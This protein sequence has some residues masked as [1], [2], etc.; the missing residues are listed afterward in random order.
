MAA[1]IFVGPILHEIVFIIESLTHI[2]TLCLKDLPLLLFGICANGENSLMLKLS[3]SIVFAFVVHC[4][5]PG[6]YYTVFGK[7]EGR[8]ANDK[9]LFS[10]GWKVDEL[11]HL[12][13]DGRRLMVEVT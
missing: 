7:V 8:S 12:S 9:E 10:L 11:S 2:F 5:T 1:D 13:D 4:S 3:Q 6:I